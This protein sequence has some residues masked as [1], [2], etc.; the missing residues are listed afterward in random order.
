MHRKS[1]NMLRFLMKVMRS[2][3]CPAS[4]W[5]MLIIIMNAIMDISSE[6]KFINEDEYDWSGKGRGGEREGGRGG[7]GTLVG[8][9][10][11]G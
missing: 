1:I 3:D 7:R 11:M 9:A 5:G 2:L 10:S 4:F 8:D 6:F